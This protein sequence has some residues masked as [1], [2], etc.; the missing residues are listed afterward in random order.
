MRAHLDRQV[1]RGAASDFVIHQH[2]WFLGGTEI[3]PAGRRHISRLSPRLAYETHQVIIEPSEP[4]LKLHA[5]VKDAALAAQE[6]DQV[7]RFEV[8]QMLQQCGVL[9][10]EMRVR[11]AYPQAEGLN[12]AQATRIFNSLG[13]GGPGS[14]SGSSAGGGL[15]GFGGG[16][17]STGMTGGRF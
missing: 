14:R 15:G 6:L 11:I 2:E 17:A 16:A 8:I 9:D 12:G 10:A 13:R 5:S 7:R 3:G 1:H 4:D